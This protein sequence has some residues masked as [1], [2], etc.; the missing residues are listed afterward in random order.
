MF[1]TIQNLVFVRWEENSKRKSIETCVTMFYF[2][3]KS[4]NPE[5]ILVNQT[6]SFTIHHSEAAG[7][8]DTD[9]D[10][11]SGVESTPYRQLL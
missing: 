5:Q 9:P 6:W 1:E 7:G 3:S 10:T 11:N 8:T 2:L 4:K